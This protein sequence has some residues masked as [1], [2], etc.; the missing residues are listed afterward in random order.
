MKFKQILIL[1]LT[2]FFLGACAKSISPNA[3]ITRDFDI[4]KFCGGWYEIAHIKG[5]TGELENTAYEIFVDKNGSINMLKSAQSQS[6]KIKLSS[7]ELAF[8]GKKSEGNLVRKGMIK[9]AKFSVAQTDVDYSYALIFGENTGELYMLSRTKTMPELIK[10][11]YLNKAKE[12]G[13]DTQKIVWTK[14]K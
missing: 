13:Y 1:T 3:P 7:E 6:G 2:I 11:I 12:S 8:V 4:A 10:N 14:Q 5:F 9:N